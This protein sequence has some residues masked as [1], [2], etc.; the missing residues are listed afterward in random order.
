MTIADQLRQ[1][2]ASIEAGRDT[3]ICH[4]LASNLGTPRWGG[5]GLPASLFLASLG[6]P[7][8]GGGFAQYREEGDKKG[9]PL[10]ERMELR[11]AWCYFAADIADEWG[12]E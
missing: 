5:C 3:F 6:M 8:D 2:A 10:N 7:L 12:V 4:A 9:L 11:V 1:A